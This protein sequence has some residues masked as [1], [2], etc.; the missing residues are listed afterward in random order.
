MNAKNEFEKDFF[1]LMNN[2]VFGKTMENVRNHR[3]IKLVTTN[4]QRNKFAS[5]P[6]YHSTKYILEDLLVMEMKKTEVKMNQLIYLSQAILDISK[7]LMYEIWCDYIKPKYEDKARLCHMDTDSFI[8]NIKTQDFYEDISDDVEKWFDTSNYDKN[9]KRLLPIRINKKVLGMFKD[10][11]KGKIIAEFVPLR[12][13]M[14]T[15]LI[16]GYNDEDYEKNNIINKKCKRTKKY[17]IKRELMFENYKESSFVVK[18][19]LKSQLEVIITRYIQKK[20]IK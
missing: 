3:D 4:K 13:K 15:H 14:Y 8:I 6:N 9:D 20:L 19:L 11:L 2:S 16:G 5:E 12:A 17:V 18:V 10:E 1:K 7:T